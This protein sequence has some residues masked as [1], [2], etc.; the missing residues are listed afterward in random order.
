MVGSRSSFPA[1]AVSISSSSPGVASKPV[2]TSQIGEKKVR[3]LKYIQDFVLNSYLK[4]LSAGV[5]LSGG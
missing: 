5:F 4:F 3:E 1:E 2:S